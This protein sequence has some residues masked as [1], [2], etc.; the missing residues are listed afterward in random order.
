[1]VLCQT[2]GRIIAASRD[3]TLLADSHHLLGNEITTLAELAEKCDCVRLAEKFQVFAASEKVFES[4]SLRLKGS[5]YRVKL[6]KLDEAQGRYLIM[7]ELSPLIGGDE[8]KFL[9]EAGR[10]TA[11]LIHDFKNQMGG[12]KLYAAYLKKRF[13]DQPEGLEIA[14]K[15]IQGLNN[16]AE[17][18]ALVNKLTRPLELNREV[19]DLTQCLNQAVDGL[20]SRADSRQVKFESEI[21]N[22][23]QL[24]SFDA[25]HLR[26]ALS[27]IIARAVDSSPES[28]VVRIILRSIPGEMLIE[29]VDRGETLGEEQ[30]QRIFNFISN[31]RLNNASFELA[32]ARRIIEQH[33]GQ[34][35]AFAASTEG[36]VVQVKLPI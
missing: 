11:R 31:D 9:I 20:K 26:A 22:G 27:S 4:F 30:R 28:G 5:E 24:A 36:T 13:S 7:I 29:I 6:L 25:Q 33:G 18:A 1:M 17:H 23:L 16:M 15:I 19:K 8:Q 32:M 34:I 10:M 3:S 21:D 12:L 35:T 14:E 2:D